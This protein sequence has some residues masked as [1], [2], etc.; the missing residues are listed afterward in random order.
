MR[1]AIIICFLIIVILLF[2]FLNFYGYGTRKNVGYRKRAC[3]YTLA[4]RRVPVNKSYCPY[5]AILGTWISVDF[6]KS[7]K[8]GK[9]EI[10]LA[11]PYTFLINGEPSGDISCS[12]GPQLTIRTGNRVFVLDG[13]KLLYNGIVYEIYQKK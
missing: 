3:N 1:I 11:D 13:D 6:T 5:R 12:I 2:R 9:L 8:P 7:G 4:S 10:K